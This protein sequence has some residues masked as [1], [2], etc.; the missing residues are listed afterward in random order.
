[1]FTS[2]IHWFGSIFW[3]IILAVVTSCSVV[4]FYTIILDIKVKLLE[5]KLNRLIE[6]RKFLESQLTSQELEEIN[7]ES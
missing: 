5:W 6:K 7:N 4:Y 3:G 1:M 2:N